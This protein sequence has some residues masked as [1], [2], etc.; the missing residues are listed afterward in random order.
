M[1]GTRTK[2]SRLSPQQSRPALSRTAAFLI[3]NDD[4]RNFLVQIRP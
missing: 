3:R 2:A 1:K 4:A